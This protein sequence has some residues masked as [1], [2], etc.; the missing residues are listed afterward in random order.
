MT[1][2]DIVASGVEQIVLRHVRLP[3]RAPFVT[4]LGT[5][6][7]RNIVIVEL[8]AGG[9]VGYGEVPVLSS[10]TYNEETVETAWHVLNDFFIP[11]SMQRKGQISAQE[12]AA[13]LRLFKGHAFAKAGLE[14]A[15]WDAAAKQAGVPLS[16]L[17][18]QFATRFP[19]AAGWDETEGAAPR[20]R[21]PSGVVVGMPARGSD[22]TGDDFGPL[23][24]RIEVRLQEGYR[25]IKLK[26]EPGR[27]EAVL[28]AVREA[29]GSVDLSVDANGA[30]G[31]GDGEALS[32]LDKFGLSYIEQPLPAPD[33]IEHAALQRRLQTP[34]CLDES[35]GGMLQARQGLDLGSCRVVNVK[36]SRM[37]GLTEAVAVHNLC[38]QAGI[39]VLCGG[40]L[41]SGIGRA[42]NVALASLPGFCL[43]GDL[44]ASSR[45]WRKDLVEPA[46]QLD[47]D[48]YI[49]VPSAPGLGVDVDEDFLEHV[50]VRRRIHTLS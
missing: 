1:A 4:A 34:L 43:P 17:L 2:A 11:A 15:V 24:R 21:V 18:F 29:F 50:T 7:M 20:P 13:A 26:I 5:E 39:P 48:G 22:G 12:V 28:R 8:H 49:P 46:F 45:Y 36:A 10:P 42:H 14:G 33:I 32:R 23:L 25:R 31:P 38:V 44:S 6:E 35:I 19:G 27:D 41:E 47:E 30:Y 16:R 9:A 37:G 3:L 40:L